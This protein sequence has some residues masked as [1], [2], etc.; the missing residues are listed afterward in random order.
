MFQRKII[1]ISL[2][3]LPLL[4]SDIRIS[5]KVSLPWVLTNH[6]RFKRKHYHCFLLTRTFL[7]SSRR[8]T[9][10]TAQ[11]SLKTDQ[12]DRTITIRNWEN[13]RVRAHHAKSRRLQFTQ[14]SGRSIALSSGS[15]LSVFFSFQALCLAPSRELAR[16]I[17]SVVT[18]MGKYTNV[19]TEYAIKE[20]LPRDATNITAQ[21]IIGTPGTM[22]DLIRRKVHRD[23]NLFGI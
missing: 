19:Q 12:H 4:Q 5:W 14:A 3:T 7:G 9:M 20:N 2:L 15:S 21:I 16:Q 23:L 1:V 13:C 11:Y 17:M 18:A 8:A 10:L 6:R 22:M